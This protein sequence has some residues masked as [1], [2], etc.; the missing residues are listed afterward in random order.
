MTSSVLVTDGQLRSGLAVVRSLGAR[1]VRVVCGE[2][3]RVATAK[4]SKYVDDTIVYPSPDTN[5]AGFLDA[6]ESVLRTDDIDVVI[7]V[8]H[9]TTALLSEHRERFSDLARIPVPPHETFVNGWDKA[10]TFC[11]AERAGVP[12]P[13]TECPDGPEEAARVADAIGY[14]VVIKARTSSGSRGLEFVTSPDE[15]AAAYERVHASY[16][17]PLVQER[18]PQEGGMYGAAFIYNDDY[19]PRV[20]FACEFVREFPPSGGPSTLHRSINGEDV[21]SHARD[22]LDEL[23][24]TGAALVE[25][26]GDVRDDT[27]KLMEVNPRLW[28]SLHLPMFA[29][30]DFPWRY[31]QYANG[32]EVPESFNY[33]TDVYS[34]YILPGDLLRLAA[35]RNR[36]A[37][38]EFFPLFADGLN[39]EIPA[40]DDPGPT[41]GR[42]A[43]IGRYAASPK[44]WRKAILRR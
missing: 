30:I 6:I 12:R 8:A 17:E 43:A 42:L 2:S 10:E 32:D 23:N 28:S 37:L 4:L 38:R 18:I 20:G 9:E 7:P 31:L 36:E 3:T 5:P 15:F 21:R 24:W 40:L 33:E 29:G 26:K 41:L 27:P 22:L 11:A 13:Q 1:D 44:M 16:P 19:E 39:Y 35:V 34:R 25:F 14:P